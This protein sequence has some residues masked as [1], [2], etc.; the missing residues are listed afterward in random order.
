MYIYNAAGQKLEKIVKDGIT[1]TNTN[2]L[3]G[4]QYKDN[5]LEFFPTAEGYVKNENNVLS[6][7]FQYKDHLGNT[8]LSYA[9]NPT[10]QVLEIIE[11]NNYYPFGLKHKGYNDVLA[12]NNKYKFLGQERQDELGLN[13]DTF[14]HRNYDYAIGRF[15]GVDP[16][17]EEYMSISTYQFAHN[18]PVWKIEIEGL[19]GAPS[20]G[21]TDITN[22]EPIKVKN[23]PV[24]GLV[25]TVFK[26]EVVQ[27][28]APKVVEKVAG[29]LSPL[30]KLTTNV[31]SIVT[32]VLHDYMSPNF[33]RTN[34]RPLKFDIKVDEKSSIKDHKVEEK[35]L[36]KQG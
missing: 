21:K 22:H 31:V 18:N 27:Q 20:N 34:E 1:T 13:W 4:F 29:G 5:I 28:S 17:S 11:E 32:A 2:Y 9:K 35:Q 16:V 23:T 24:L 26:S 36:K 25:G 3:G 33:G 10:T 12:T 6:Y 8:R 15:F 30:A 14:R 7:V 19:E